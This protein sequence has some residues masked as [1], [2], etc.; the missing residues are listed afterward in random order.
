MRERQIKFRAFRDFRGW[1]KIRETLNEPRNT[2]K[3]RKGFLRDYVVPFSF[4]CVPSVD[5]GCHAIHGFS[6]ETGDY[7]ILGIAGIR[8]IT[9]RRCYFVCRSYPQSNPHVTP[10]LLFKFRSILLRAPPL[11]PLLLFKILCLVFLQLLPDGGERRLPVARLRLAE[12]AHRVIPGTVSPFEL[13][14]PVWRKGDEGPSFL[15]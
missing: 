8:Y 14:A 13:P 5:V 12:E 4:S 7:A 10:V 15:A 9:C 11:L 3:T 1:I 2:R 6:E